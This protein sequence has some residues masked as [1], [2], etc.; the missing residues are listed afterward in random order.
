MQSN[1]QKEEIIR[2]KMAELEKLQSEVDS[3]QID[4]DDLYEADQQQDGQKTYTADQMLIIQCAETINNIL[5]DVPLS[6]IKATR[7]VEARNYLLYLMN[8]VEFIPEVMEQRLMEQA[9]K[10]KD[11]KPTSAGQQQPTMKQQQPTPSAKPKPPVKSNEV[12]QDSADYFDDDDD[13]STVVDNLVE[14]EKP[15]KSES[16]LEI[17][18]KKMKAIDSPEGLLTKKEPEKVPDKGLKRFI[19]TFGK[20]KPIDRDVSDDHQPTSMG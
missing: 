20:K 12:I 1:T 7:L 15:K 18:S 19:P 11:E 6:R 2:Q 13:I 16:D 9:E 17:I 10:I 14:P 5:Q 3:Q 4:D 8:L